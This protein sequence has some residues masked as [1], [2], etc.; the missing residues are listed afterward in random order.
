MEFIWGTPISLLR[1][2]SPGSPGWGLPRKAT[3]I[4]LMVPALPPSVMLSDWQTDVDAR[5]KASAQ[6]VPTP[7]TAQSVPHI[8]AEDV[9]SSQSPS[10]REAS[11]QHGTVLPCHAPPTL[12]EE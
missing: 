2:G 9:W 5:D 7:A 4:L 11:V 10:S 3:R 12:P 8:E 6:P 1:G